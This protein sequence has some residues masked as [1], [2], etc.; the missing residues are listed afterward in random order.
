MRM[1]IPA[2]IG[3]FGILMG[4]ARAQTPDVAALQDLG[5]QVF[6][7][8]ISVPARQSCASCHVAEDGWTSGSA[9]T[10]ERQVVVRGAARHAFG[11]RK[12]P[13]SAYAAFSANFVPCGDS[14][15]DCSGGIFWDGRAT[16][17]AIGPEVF[18]ANS[19][20]VAA[21]GGFLGPTADQALGP[22]ANPVEQNVDP[23]STAIAGAQAVCSAVAA[24][25]YAELFRLAW[26][27]APDC[28]GQ[29]ELEFKRIAVAISAYEHSSEVNSFSSLRDQALEFDA[30][31]LFPLEALTDEENLGHDLFF[32][33][34]SAGGAGCSTCHSGVP[35]GEVS[36]G[37]GDEPHQLFRG[38]GFQNI[39]LP[40]NP[41][42]ANF[43]PDAPDGGLAAFTGNPKHAG[44]F[45]NPTLRNVDARENPNFPKAYMH[46]GYFKTL[47][48]VVHFY[49][50]ANLKPL[51]LVTNASAAEAIANDCWPAAE[52]PGA[53]GLVGDLGLSAEEE[54]ALVA[55]LRTLSDTNRVRKP[56]PYRKAKGK[57]N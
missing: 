23:G 45:R 26:G 5:K 38:R 39:G 4:T 12:P 47:E 44:F 13:T 46:N 57:K 42:I 17:T 36:T 11:G 28:A 20:L 30:D 43:S 9:R 55:Y 21:Y 37:R 56:A 6:F 16:G 29:P 19:L 34:K 54:A 49:N 52:F 50:T 51:C 27:A 41:A 2:V 35:Q 10:N 8:D 48:Q 7:D 40:A 53:S 18:G 24:A 25:K 32:T 22:F 14:V 15:R 31:H 33:S 3:S 1:N